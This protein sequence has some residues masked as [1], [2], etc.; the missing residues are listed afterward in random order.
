MY[1]PILVLYI[2]SQLYSRKIKSIIN[3]KI[4][5]LGECKIREDPGKY[6]ES[7]TFNNEV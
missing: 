4:V 3:I 7:S 2:K 5:R 6:S 1:C